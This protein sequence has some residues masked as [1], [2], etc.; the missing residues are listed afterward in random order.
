VDD[1]EER[2]RRIEEALDLRPGTA[3]ESDPQTRTESASQGTADSKRWDDDD[4]HYVPERREE[5]DDLPLDPYPAEL[6]L[7]VRRARRREDGYYVV[8]A[9]IGNYGE[10]GATRVRWWLSTEEGELVSTVGGGDEKRIGAG[11]TTQLEV[12]EIPGWENF[13]FQGLWCR[14]AWRD[15]DGD[16]EKRRRFT[17]SSRGMWKWERKQRREERSRGAP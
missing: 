2:L 13:A 15:V 4:P 17:E 7:S 1:H 16:H 11:E 3:R 14:L 10:G 9:E 6:A 5:A 12:V 8:L